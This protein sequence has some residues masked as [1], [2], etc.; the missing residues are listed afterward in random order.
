MKKAATLFVA[1][2]IA[3]F[4]VAACGDSDDD[5][6]TSAATT[7]TAASTTAAGGGGGTVEIAADP[8]A[9]EFTTTEFTTKAGPTTIDF[10]NPSSTPHDVVLTDSSGTEVGKTDLISQGQDSFTADLKAG[11]Y[12]FVCDVPGHTETMKGTITVN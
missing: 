2:A 7:D 6:D 8:S 10:D 12:E 3:A 1:G 4:G 9:L 5:S 11:T